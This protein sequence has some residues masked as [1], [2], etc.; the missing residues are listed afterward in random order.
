MSMYATY[1]TYEAY[2][3]GRGSGLTG[4]WFF[5]NFRRPTTFKLI[6]TSIVISLRAHP[7]SVHWQD[8]LLY[9]VGGYASLTSTYSDCSQAADML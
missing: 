3:A 5:A 2:A 8:A 4:F 7:D 6:F 1:A 9:V